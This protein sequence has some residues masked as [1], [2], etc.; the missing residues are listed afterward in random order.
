MDSKKLAI[1]GVIVVFLGF[2]MF[3]D[4]GGL[5]EIAK[6]ASSTGWNMATDLFSVIIDFVTSF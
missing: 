2:W 4:P 5:A 6:S 1:V 3:T